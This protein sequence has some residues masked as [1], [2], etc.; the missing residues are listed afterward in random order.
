MQINL[1]QGY[2]SSKETTTI[3]TKMVDLIIKFEEDKIKTAVN[4]AAASIRG[5]KIKQLQKNLYELRDF[6]EKQKGNIS[7]LCRMEVQIEK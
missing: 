7:I 3:I 1:T 5:Q 6:V 4:E 2:Y